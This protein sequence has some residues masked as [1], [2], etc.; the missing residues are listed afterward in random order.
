MGLPKCRQAKS[1]TRRLIVIELRIVAEKEQTFQSFG[2][3]QD[4][5]GH[6]LAFA[7]QILDQPVDGPH[8]TSVEHLVLASRIYILSY[9]SSEGLELSRRIPLAPL[10][11]RLWK[12]QY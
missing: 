3:A 8:D 9:H 5:P 11:E 1:Q 12:A 6:P 7:S 4:L 2:F 10:S